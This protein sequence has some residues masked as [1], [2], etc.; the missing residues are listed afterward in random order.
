MDGE[1]KLSA[2]NDRSNASSMSTGTNNNSQQQGD[3][4]VLEEEIDPNYEPTQEEVVEYAKWLGMDIEHDQD[5]L[6]IAREGLKAPLPPH[7]KPCKTTD[8]EEVYYFNFSDGKSTWDHPCDEHY[9][10]LYAKEKRKKTARHETAAKRK[11]KKKAKADAKRLIKSQIDKKPLGKIGAS[12]RGKGGLNK[13][14]R[15]KLSG[16][17]N[18]P[19][20]RAPLMQ[21]SKPLSSSGLGSSNDP[22][23]SSKSSSRTGGKKTG[24]SALS[25]DLDS[26]KAI[27]ATKQRKPRRT[28]SGKGGKYDDMD[29]SI[30]NDSESESEDEKERRRRRSSITKLVPRK[31]GRRSPNDSRNDSYDDDSEDDYARRRER[32]RRERKRRDRERDR[33]DENQR[34]KQ[35]LKDLKRQHAAEI[36]DLKSELEEKRSNLQRKNRRELKSIKED[37]ESE[38]KEMNRQHK[39][40]KEKMNEKFDRKLE[41]LRRDHELQLRE[42]T[43]KL[44][45]KLDKEMRDIESEHQKRKR[46]FDSKSKRELKSAQEKLEKERRMFETKAEELRL[47][48]NSIQKDYISDEAK[49]NDDQRVGLEDELKTWKTKYKT[50]VADSERLKEDLQDK[51]DELR[52]QKRESEKK[53]DDIQTE[54]LDSQTKLRRVERELDEIQSE[55]KDLKAKLEIARK[56]KSSTGSSDL[57]EYKIDDAEAKA[58][59]REN[60]NREM[61]KY[62]SNLRKEFDSFKADLDTRYEREREAHERRL[63]RLSEES[64]EKHSI[65]VVA[66]SVDAEEELKR[67]K[68]QKERTAKEVEELKKKLG[69]EAKSLQDAHSAKLQNLEKDF[70]KTVGEKKKRNREELQRMDKELQQAEE[71]LAERL[72][73]QEAKAHQESQNNAD[74]NQGSKSEGDLVSD[75]AAKTTAVDSLTLKL[76]GANGQVDRLNARV[77]RLQK[78][79]ENNAKLECQ[80]EDLNDDLESE[81]RKSKFVQSKLEREKASLSKQL[82]ELQGQFNTETLRVEQLERKH[83]MDTDQSH[84]TQRALRKEITDL[85]ETNRRLGRELKD[86][87]EE[88]Q[89]E[90]EA[91]KRISEELEES[92]EQNQKLKMENRQLISSAAESTTVSSQSS[93][94]EKEVESLMGDMKNLRAQLEG[95]GQHSKNRYEVLE[96]KL[97]STERERNEWKEKF[98]AHDEEMTKEIKRLVDER[99]QAITNVDSASSDDNEASSSVLTELKMRL[100]DAIKEKDSLHAS[101][102]LLTLDKQSLETSV[103]QK[104]ADFERLL[105]R[106]EE[107]QGQHQEMVE[108]ISRFDLER[109]TF[110][111]ME[112]RLKKSQEE[113]EHTKQTLASKVKELTDMTVYVDNLQKRNQV[114]KESK[115]SLEHDMTNLKATISNDVTRHAEEMRDVNIKLREAHAQLRLQK[116]SAEASSLP[117][118]ASMNT[119][120]SFE[121]LQLQGK[122]NQLEGKLSMNANK[123]TLQEEL[124]QLKIVKLQNKAEKASDELVE[125]KTKLEATLKENEE[126]KRKLQTQYEELMKLKGG[127]ISGTRT[128]TE[129]IDSSPVSDIP[130]SNANQAWVEE[131]KDSLAEERSQNRILKENRQRESLELYRRRQ[132]LVQQSASQEELNRIAL[133]TE[134]TMRRLSQQTTNRVRRIESELRE[135][136]E[137]VRKESEHRLHALRIRLK[138]QEAEAITRAQAYTSTNL[139][140]P[141]RDTTNTTSGET[142]S[143]RT[144]SGKSTEASTAS[145]QT[146]S[147]VQTSGYATPIYQQ[148]QQ[149]PVYDAYERQ[150]RSLRFWHDRVYREKLLIT[151]ARASFRT[152][153][154]ALH[155]RVAQ[156]KAD[157]SA[158]KKESLK[159][160]L[161]ARERGAQSSSKNSLLEKARQILDRQAKTYNMALK[162]MDFSKKWLL[163]R[164][165]KIQ[166][167]EATLTELRGQLADHGDRTDPISTADSSSLDESSLQEEDINNSRTANQSLDQT[168]GELDA[169]DSELHDDLSLI[170]FE[171]LPGVGMNVDDEP[172]LFVQD[173]E[174]EEENQQPETETGHEKENSR[175]ERPT[176]S[177]SS[178]QTGNSLIDQEPEDVQS[179]GP[180]D[181][182]R[183][184]LRHQMNLPREEPALPTS[185]SSI[186]RQATTFAAKGRQQAVATKERYCDNYFHSNSNSALPQ[187]LNI[188]VRGNPDAVKIR[189]MARV[190]KYREEIQT[191]RREQK[192][193]NRRV[194]EGYIRN[195]HDMDKFE[196]GITTPAAP[197]GEESPRKLEQTAEIRKQV[198]QN[199][200]HGR[201]HTREAFQRHI[202]WLQSFRKQLYDQ[203]KSC[204]AISSRKSKRKKKSVKRRKKKRTQKT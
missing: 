90:V 82:D 113:I 2:R 136:E 148:Q 62:R 194:Y 125:T 200:I 173:I 114:L 181:V 159:A 141:L 45:T 183:T 193:E 91:R 180:S 29:D 41:T 171:P 102:R 76:A 50:A 74:D 43:R 104:N 147:N 191:R 75:L 172:E 22:L 127:S 118:T 182:D 192:Q 123:A 81:R 68:E 175:N 197:R 145:E 69:D 110:S 122:I 42:D 188:N 63:K 164:E 59:A 152:Y 117:P 66:A 96:M 176:I 100:Q 7:W 30:N 6:W 26:P 109:N 201:E 158:W 10:E 34:F 79:L 189:E 161:K 115:Q 196:T 185:H 135:E 54:L 33:E 35:E 144:S 168:W 184:Q 162:Q 140:P 65:A 105:S 112:F 72:K 16:L 187:P 47:K 165:A 124:H 97:A 142:Y 195:K 139:R 44:E 21:K 150:R 154:K 106:Y 48:R 94:N 89:Q 40:K 199:Y 129:S 61:E 170:S 157:R 85:K 32:K 133:E 58:E 5:L 134:A 1:S 51:K 166:K 155:Q 92:K 27:K 39:E 13:L 128:E 143:G 4:I 202:D 116:A 99:N 3:S 78:E 95:K 120:S 137:R 121:L 119:G 87:H 131:V 67:L 23:T 60:H 156:L 73:E 56:Q 80:V 169:I 190:K 132:M 163:S 108:K 93:Y 111:R 86:Q 101:N 71:K 177:S 70:E 28:E 146:T 167:M 25:D 88:V 160:K 18:N 64:A 103:K 36:S 46:N 151:Q 17:S 203:Q 49:L 138:E 12:K 15:K 149:V 174:G 20:D 179:Q 186:R 52:T 98:I 9:R 19:L 198:R 77:E 126:M 178:A 204:L 14:D 153:R 11:G 57:E 83:S 107:Q 84:K 55:K 31:L 53:L 8:T 24:I 37:H 38:V 130:P